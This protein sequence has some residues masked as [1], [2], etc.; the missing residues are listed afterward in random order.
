MTCLVWWRGIQREASAAGAERGRR[1]RGWAQRG[2]TVKDQYITLCY[3][4]G[5]AAE[6]G[7]DLFDT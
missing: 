1:G 7:C 6:E 3:M 5:L 2:F 4:G